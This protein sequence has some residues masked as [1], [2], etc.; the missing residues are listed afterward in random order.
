VFAAAAAAMHAV[1][2]LAYVLAATVVEFWISPSV[3]L[4]FSIAQSARV[5]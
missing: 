4:D 3:E 2:A 5:N 1:V